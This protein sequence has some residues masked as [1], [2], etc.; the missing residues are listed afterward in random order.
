MRDTEYLLQENTKVPDQ[1]V[2]ARIGLG[3]YSKFVA[4]RNL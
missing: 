1:A 3:L 4:D 2:E